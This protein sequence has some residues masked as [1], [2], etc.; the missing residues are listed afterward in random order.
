MSN[1]DTIIVG[2]GINALVAA[3]C[4]GGKGRRVLVLE[5]N[6]RIGGCLRTEAITEEGFVHDVMATTFVLFVT[7]PAYAA[8]ADDLA[9]HGLEFCNTDTPTGVLRADGSFFIHRR[10]RQAN[11]AA[12]NALAAGEGERYNRDVVSVE[13]NA[14]LIFG[15]LGGRVWSLATARLL[16]REAWRRGPRQL[17]AFFGEALTPARSWLEGGYRSET[18]RALWA[19]WALHAGLGPEDTFSGQISK[20]IAFALEAAGAPIAK[21][22]A[23]TLLQAF[24]GLIE[25]QGGEIRTGADVDEVLTEG[26]RARG[27]RLASGETI[28]AAT[29]ACSVTPDQLYGRLLKTTPQPGA[30]AEA[31]KRYRYGKGNFQL[32]YALDRPPQ[33]RG[34]G[35]GDV[36]LLHLTSGLDAVSK[37]CNEALRGM[38]PEEPTI[39]V[40]QPHA[41][42]PTR[43]PPGKAIL[44][45]QLPEAPR[46]VRGDAAG[47]LQVPTKGEWT[48]ELREDYAD[49]VEAILN[50]HIDGF[51]DTVI[52]RRAYSPA[53]LEAMNINLV[54]GDPY[55]G[56]STVDQSFLWR[57]FKSSV[58]HRTS[59]E[60]L[61]HIGAST[62]PGAG[63]GGGS[64]YLLAEKL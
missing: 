20:V 64:G 2:S 39:C 47:K 13:E 27:V 43:C 28:H 50:R 16:A 17:A 36:A 54:G 52:S 57:P 29:V 59:I 23:A 18:A 48:E 38:L 35:L 10:D 30:V 37:A 58:N 8:L 1:P 11:I 44:W 60:G 19:P 22:G 31:V 55:G 24:R 42:D 21:G 12:F 45:L 53:D 9:R 41:L 51:S 46:V 62:H 15:L 4:L 56:S 14:G 32:H 26:G 3:A 49:R 33:W 25:E 5:R 63:L 6:D 40:G 61:Y 7:S 34:E